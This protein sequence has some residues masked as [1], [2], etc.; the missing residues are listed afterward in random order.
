MGEQENKE[1]V[2][3]FNE[4]VFNQHNKAAMDEL[5]A[6]EAV[7]HDPLPGLS[8]DKAGAVAT[9]EQILAA[10]PDMKAEVHQL[11]A[12]GDQVAVRAT[13][14]GTHEG[15]FM[16][17]PPT[18]KSVEVGS[19]DIVRVKDGKFVEHWGIFDA[20]GMMMQLGVIQSPGGAG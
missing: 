6:D 1:L 3:R 14:R 18:G 20:A 16:G 9:I 4:E 19:I 12:S 15:E 10:F 17:V 7:E 2:Q 11:V 8:N 13:F 5:I